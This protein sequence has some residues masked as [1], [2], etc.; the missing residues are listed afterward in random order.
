MGRGNQE[1][2]LTDTGATGTWLS[3]PGPQGREEGMSV[4]PEPPL[5]CSV[6][7][8]E[9]E[10]A[11]P[12]PREMTSPHRRACPPGKQQFPTAWAPGS[13]AA[14]DPGTRRLCSVRSLGILPSS[15]Q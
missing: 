14:R 4:V 6:W 7:Q 15:E 8:P 9:T 12:R 5:S 1:A 13:D 10:A 2:A 11:C 3:D